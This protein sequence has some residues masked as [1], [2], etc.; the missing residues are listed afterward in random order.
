M[1]KE[2]HSKK[3]TEITSKSKNNSKGITKDKDLEAILGK[4]KPKTKASS[5]SNEEK[6][7]LDSIFSQIKRNRAASQPKPSET[8]IQISKEEKDKLAGKPTKSKQI[9][10]L[11]FS[12]PSNFYS[13][14]KNWAYHRRRLPNLHSH[15]I[16][17]HLRGWN[18]R[19]LSI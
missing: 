7:D 17:S 16:R 3:S 4:I 8:V 15:P 11:K 12:F 1:K 19:R 5:T 2:T 18:Y 10:V 9:L 13:F 14:R 6:L